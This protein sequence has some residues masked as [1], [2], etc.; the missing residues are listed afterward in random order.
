VNGPWLASLR[1]L[2]RRRSLNVAYHGVDEVRP[3]QD[4]ENLCIAPARFREQLELLT[5]AGFELMTVAE[6]AERAAGG[7]PPPGLASI[8]FD[9]GLEDNHRV[10]LPILRELGVAATVYVTTGFIGRPNEWMGGRA[11]YMTEDELRD[12]RRAGFELGAH[13]VSHPDL[14]TL[15]ADDC[16]REVRE[17]MA[18]VEAIAG[19]PVRTF[20]YPFCRYGDEAIA[21]VR[22]AGLLAAVTCEGRGDWSP[23]TMKRA[24]ITGKDG[25]ASFVAKLWDVYQPAFESPP[26]RAVRAVSRVPRTRLRASRGPRAQAPPD[27]PGDA[28]DPPA[29]DALAEARGDA[30]DLAV[31]APAPTAGGSE[32]A[33]ARAARNTAA[34]AAG[35]FLA[36]LASLAFYA[37]LARKLGQSGVGVFVFALAWAEI[38]MLLASLGLDRALVRW[39]AHDRSRAASLFADSTSIKASLAV[40][41]ALVSFA[42]VN[43]LTVGS[44][45]RMTIYVLTLGAFFDALT[46]AA[47]GVFTALERAELTAASTI[48]QRFL[49]A[50]LGIGAL[51]AGGGVVAASVTYTVAAGVGFVLAVVLMR[52]RLGVA[53]AAPDPGRWRGLAVTSIPFAVQD[54][55]TVLLFRLDAVLLSL[56]ASTA[57]VGRYGASYRLFESTFFLTYALGAAF[58]PMY[59][60]LRNDGEPTIQ[61]AFQRSLKMSLLLL[62]PCA[63][64]F[65]T[66]PEFVSR[67]IFGSQLEAA[68]ASL[69]ILAPVVVLIGLVT[70]S[71]SLIVSR[72]DPRTILVLSGAMTLLNVGLNLALI[73]S[74]EE[75][76]AAIAMVAT[77]GVFLA[78]ALAMALRTLGTGLDWLSMGAAPLLAGLAMAAVTLALRG[79]PGWAL[80]AG[81]VVYP[82]VFA[83]AERLISPG[84]LAFVVDFLRRRMGG[85]ASRR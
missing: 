68:S 81:A 83:V 60:Y 33:F 75:R 38:S 26:G 80:G 51:V 11:R 78:L 37:V 24:L 5:R 29:G 55:F 44:T 74:L 53:R 15:G 32:Q 84:D 45:S 54:A 22:D 48:V 12:L 50:G 69:R 14:S 46:R 42:L 63:V 23:Y 43:V 7:E 20:A 49:A 66:L 10:V 57:A 34:R 47:V 39:I 64:V 72:R 30:L 40:P 65:A 85:R 2:A 18:A 36:K 73:P 4:P 62:V 58:S 71:S 3:E 59:T 61:G 77:E 21:A 6:L 25:L 16:R 9:D 27:S 31:G 35:E 41:I 76:G 17:S 13:S 52:R 67:T 79:T 70:L 19:E 1:A 28:L 82:L 8:S 56:I